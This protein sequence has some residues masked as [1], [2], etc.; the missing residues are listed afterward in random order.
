MVA[1]KLSWLVIDTSDITM[2]EV[3]KQRL[4]SINKM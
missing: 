4:I 3:V 2:N 1:K